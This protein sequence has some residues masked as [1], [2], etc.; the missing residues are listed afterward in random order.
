MISGR[1]LLLMDEPLANLDP[2]MKARLRA[3]LL[4][5][6][7][8]HM[9]TIV[10]VT[11][12]QAEAR[13]LAD[14]IAVMCGGRLEQVDTPDRI[15]REP[16]TLFVAG[17]VGEPKVNVVLGRL[18]EA[19]DGAELTI[20]GRTIRLPP[21]VLSARPGLR[22]RFGSGVLVA[23]RPEHLRWG[24][25]P[26]GS[27]DPQRIGGTVTVVEFLGHESLVHFD[28][29]AEAADGAPWSSFRATAP[30]DAD[31]TP[32]SHV[33]FAF[34]PGALRFFDPDDHAAIGR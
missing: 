15:Y 14:R 10:Y 31:I 23:L 25:A 2:A 4:E 21:R 22:R 13:Y 12:D 20:G 28:V 6:K 16:A 34:D 1:R 29:D 33:A 24:A 5:M 27:G 30:A 7:R 18:E 26:G 19:A 11:N 17:F 9:P 3:D 32:G 8:R